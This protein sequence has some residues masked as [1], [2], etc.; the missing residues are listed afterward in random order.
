MT[1]SSAFYRKGRLETGLKLL[2]MSGSR[3]GFLIISSISDTVQRPSSTG[4]SISAIMLQWVYKVKT[5][6]GV[7]VFIEG[8]SLLA[9]LQ[10]QEGT[11]RSNGA[12]QLIPSK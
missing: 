8:L 3:P 9:F 5:F 2:M 1:R 4:H 10:T 7:K 12:E 11:S 6:L